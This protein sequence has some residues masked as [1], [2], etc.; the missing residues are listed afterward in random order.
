MIESKIK[1]NFVCCF[2]SI[3]VIEGLVLNENND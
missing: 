3:F 2:Y 1:I